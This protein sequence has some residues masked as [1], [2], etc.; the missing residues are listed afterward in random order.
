MEASAL[1]KIQPNADP[2]SVQDLLARL[3]QE[4][5]MYTPE[6]IHGKAVALPLEKRVFDAL[7]GLDPEWRTLLSPPNLPPNPQS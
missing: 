2:R 6:I 5:R 3:A 1:W 4:L 7:D